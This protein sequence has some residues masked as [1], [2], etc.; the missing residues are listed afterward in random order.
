MKKLLTLAILS[1]SL[2][3]SADQGSGLLAKVIPSGKYRMVS[4][5]CFD[6]GNLYNSPVTIRVAGDQVEITVYGSNPFSISMFEGE[7]KITE[8]DKT[9]TIKGGIAFGNGFIYDEETRKG[10]FILNRVEYLMAWNDGK[11]NFSK[12]TRIN[13]RHSTKSWCDLAPVRY[14]NF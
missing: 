6:T 14:D 9:V 4:R 7:V 8:D 10:R 13:S 5:N 1:T 2:G 11:I 12:K 3:A